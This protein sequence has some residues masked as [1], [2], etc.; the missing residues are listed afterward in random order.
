MSARK[1]SVLGW[2]RPVRS[3]ED[4][5]L[6]EYRTPRRP[7]RGAVYLVLALSLIGIGF[8]VGVDRANLLVWLLALLPLLLATVFASWGLLDLV[9]RGLFELEVD[10]RARTLALAMPTEQGQALAKV[11]FAE[12]TGV[13]VAERRPLPGGRGAVRWAV[14]LAVQ[15]GRKIGLGLLDDAAEAERLAAS[16]GGLL[17]V[18]TTRSVH[19]SRE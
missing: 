1:E 16:F 10:R 4:T 18:A 14:S 9:T 6:Y 17:G 19:E 12:V 8:K 15:D 13:A 7:L 5:V 2:V 3:T 11:G